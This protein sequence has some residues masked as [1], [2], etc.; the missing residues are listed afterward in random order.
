MER[1]KGHPPQLVATQAA[2]AGLAFTFLVCISNVSSPG[3]VYFGL[4]SGQAS[5]NDQQVLVGR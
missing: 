2:A 1:L 3:L 4:S 5:K